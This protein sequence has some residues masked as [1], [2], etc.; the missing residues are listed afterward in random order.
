M[1]N[2]Q[3]DNFPG[4]DGDFARSGSSQESLLSGTTLFF[5]EQPS[6]PITGVKPSYVNVTYVYLAAYLDHDA[7]FCYF[8]FLLAVL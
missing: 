8:F 5:V 6:Y 1:D 3:L 2:S 7:L 4:S